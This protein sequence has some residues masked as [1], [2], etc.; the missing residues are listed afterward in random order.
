MDIRVRFLGAAQS[1]TGSKYL[2]EVDDHKIL[3]D[4]GLFQ[5]LKELRLKN[6]D[7]FP[8]DIFTINQVVLTHAHLDHTG[9]LPKLFK[10]GYEGPVYCSNATEDLIQLILLDSAKLQEEEAQFARKKGYSKHA[11]PQP[12]YTT[13]DA[14]RVF[15]YLKSFEFDVDVNLTERIS[16]RFH[17]A[18]HLLGSSILEFT[19]RGDNQTKKIVFSGDLG[20]NNQ[21]IL[22][23]PAILKEADVLFVE[24]TYGDRENPFN[25]PKED[26]RKFVLEALD[27]KGCLLIPAFSI[28]RTQQIIYY[29]KELLEEELIPDIPVYINSPMAISATEVYKRN[30]KYHKLSDN[31]LGNTRRIFEYKNMQ[32]CRDQARSVEL[33]GIK[34]GAIIIS[35]SGMCT[36]G[37]ILHHLYHRLP[38]PNDTLLFVGYQA[39]GT[40]G[41]KIL[42]GEPTVKMF[43]EEVP[44][45]CNVRHLDGLSAHAD[46]VELMQWLSHFEKSPKYT[47]VVHGEK[48]V[49]ERFAKT[50]RK[51]L[52]WNAYVPQYFESVEL[53]RGI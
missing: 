37:R 50:I 8:I 40:R 26:L 29:L 4:C 52:G 12:L 13:D 41:R 25:S 32:Y 6:W 24:S 7:A 31:D 48:Q 3:V 2:L 35:A 20:R 44:V 21:P 27:N 19:I 53:F 34:S 23:D 30:Y 47:F 33:N 18:G 43:G 39:E 10:E 42:D 17:E 15:P 1:V 38:R 28:G 9:Y 22:R 46:K 5:G 14:K 51:E 36:G 45:K 16:V 11:D 49:S